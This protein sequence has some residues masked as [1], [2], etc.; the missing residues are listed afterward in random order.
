MAKQHLS[1]RE[2]LE[3]LPYLQYLH[4]QF[5][6]NSNLKYLLG[7]CYAEENIVNPESIKLLKEATA[8]ASLEYNP[9]SIKEDRVPIYVYYYLS[10]AYS[11]NGLCEKANFAREQFLEIYPHKDPFYIDESKRWLQTCKGKSIMPSKDNIPQFP[12][13]EPL[14][15]PEPKIILSKN[16]P[17]QKE[18][19]LKESIGAKNQIER[20]SEV[21][22][23]ILTKRIEYSTDYP[24]YGV[25]LGAFKEVVPVS[26]FKD[27]KNVDAFMDKKGLIRYVVG[28]FS[29]NSQAESLLK[30]IKGK[31]YKDA[32]IVNVNNERKYADEVISVNNI[33]IRASLSGEISYHIQ[34]GAFRE[35]ISIETAEIYFK[36][37]GINEHRERG[38]TYLIVGKQKSYEESK[39]YLQGIKDTGINDAFV[40]AMNNGKKISLQQAKDF[41]KNTK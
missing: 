28:H 3:A 19:G 5:P 35:E 2:I 40:I 13:F 30:L 26:R 6:E 38:I 9:N 29:I 18:N 34:V 10:L 16:L 32:F 27:L 8:M 39:A 25:Q 17:K 4:G 41:N 20:S 22:K 23:K 21:P 14:L 31:G 36:I 12:D 7:V 15:L 1:K 11:Q 37:E 24:L 33:N